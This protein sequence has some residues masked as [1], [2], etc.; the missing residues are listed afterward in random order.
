[1]S[2]LSEA[3]QHTYSFERYVAV[4][5]TLPY[6]PLE[7]CLL[8][9]AVRSQQRWRSGAARPRAALSGNTQMRLGGRSHGYRGRE[10]GAGE[11]P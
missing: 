2:F 7:S 5:V 4:R 8:V 3:R 6:A 11:N 1:M 9:L 10:V